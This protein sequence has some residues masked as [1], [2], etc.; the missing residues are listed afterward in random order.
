MVLVN[1]SRII[2]YVRSESET[3]AFNIAKEKVAKDVPFFLE[4]V[5]LG[6][7]IPVGEEFFISN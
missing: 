4:R 5:Y 3:S 2:G 7:P 1:N 6:S